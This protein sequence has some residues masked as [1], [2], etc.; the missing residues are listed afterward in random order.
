MVVWDGLKCWL[1]HIGESCCRIV[2]E[3]EWLAIRRKGMLMDDR[4]D[5]RLEVMVHAGEGRQ[6]SAILD[7][8]RF[9][10]EV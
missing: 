6:G 7:E 2:S 4:L 10:R 9:G 5:R 3:V 8:N 1:D